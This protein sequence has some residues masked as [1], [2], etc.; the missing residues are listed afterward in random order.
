MNRSAIAFPAVLLL[1]SALGTAGA[2]APAPVTRPNILFIYADD[3]SYKTVSCYPEALPGAQTPHIDELAAN[4]VRFHGAFLGA[5]CMP[6]RAAILTGHHPH[7]IESMRMDG[8]YP[9]SAYDPQQCPFWPRTFRERGYTTAHI[10]KW[11]T[12]IDAGTH[13]DWDWQIVWNRPLH[14]ENAGR[15]Y[16]Q[17]VISFNGE[18][19]LTDGYATDNYTRWACDFVRG[20]HRSPSQPWFLWLCYGAIHGPTTPAE[21]HL[22]SH[23]GDEVRVPADI[24]GPRPG[25][26][27]YLEKT[28]A[29]RRGPQGDILADRNGGKADKKS[30][31]KQETYADYI[32]QINECVAALDE[33][34]GAVL[35]ALR[36]SG[37]L[38]NTLV[39]YTADQ[40]FAMGEHGFRIKLAPYDA[41]YRSPL[42]VSWPG[43]A[44]RGKTCAHCLTSPD[45]VATLHAAAG[46]EPGWP[47]HGRDATALLRDPASPWPY[48]AFYEFTG[49]HYGRE[50]A[51]MVNETPEQATYHQVPWYVALREDRWKLVCYLGQGVGEELYDLENDPEELVNVAGEPGNQEVKTRLR[52]A[53]AA[54]LERTGAGFALP[55]PPR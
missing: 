53:L 15:Y 9:G 7:G 51:R 22:G 31:K 28:Q 50:V 52:A 39:I 43:V 47:L 2:A 14:P 23:Q 18:E 26:P 3:Q 44:A 17:Q 54:E 48:P 46:I 20:E 24:L 34:V 33:G 36:E 13:R 27:A 21:R 38:E 41:N 32:H 35:A 37:Q 19:R 25:K 11:H 12:G 8:P 29:W 10:G 1:F 5:W 45:L 49:E 6:S 16:D 40:G 55:A 30:K 42:I 4:G